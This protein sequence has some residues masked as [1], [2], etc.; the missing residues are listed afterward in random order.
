MATTAPGTVGVQYIVFKSPDRTVRA[1]PGDGPPVI[2]DG[3]AALAMDIPV[4]LD[5]WLTGSSVEDEMT[6]LEFMCGRAPGMTG[7]PPKITV[8]GP[9]TLV[10]HADAKWH[11]VALD[12]GDAIINEHGTRQ[13]QHVT[14]SVLQAVWDVHAAQRS[15]ARRRAAAK[16]ARHH[17]RTHI[18]KKGETLRKI[19]RKVLGDETRWVQIRTLNRISDPRQVGKCTNKKKAGCIG[20]RLKMPP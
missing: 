4:I 13:R 5:G 17:K 15:A 12:W 1:L 18:V 6:R 14:V 10:R 2:T 8:T 3:Y 11:V 19:A 20:T 16:K 9:G 7:E